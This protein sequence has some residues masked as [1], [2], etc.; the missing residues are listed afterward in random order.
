MLEMIK[1]WMMGRPAVC[2]HSWMTIMPLLALTRLIPLISNF[3]YFCVTKLGGVNISELHK[4]KSLL[5]GGK[6]SKLNDTV[7]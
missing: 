1:F 5:I 6:Y 2:R 7:Q 3:I 4:S